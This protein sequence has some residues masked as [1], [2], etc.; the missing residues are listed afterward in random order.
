MLQLHYSLH[1]NTRRELMSAACLEAGVADMMAAD[2]DV[3]T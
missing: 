2:A 3:P 1:F